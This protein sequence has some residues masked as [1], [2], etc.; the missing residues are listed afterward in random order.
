MEKLSLQ[1]VQARFIW[2]CGPLLYALNRF[3][4]NTAL[5]RKISE[6]TFEALEIMTRVRAS[7]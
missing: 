5:H 6:N 7:W 1:S 4:L 2:V 3:G